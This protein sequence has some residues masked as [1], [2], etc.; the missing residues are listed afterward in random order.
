MSQKINAI[1]FSNDNAAQL[2]IF[3]ESV[4]KN[5][6]GVFD[7]NIII[8]GTE[9]YFDEAYGRVVDDKRFSHVNFERETDDF[10]EQVVEN[11]NS[12]HDYACFFLD[13]NIIYKVI[14]LEDITSQIEADDDVVCFSLRLGENTTKCY[15][16]GAENVLNDIE[17]C[18]D[19]MKWDWTL[20][21]L[22]FGYP[23]SY[24]EIKVCKRRRVGSIF[25]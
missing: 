20:H 11:L 6:P 18:G 1:V 16:L 12:K 19:F 23:F 2:N 8:K 4:N 3:L 9:E 10:R 14:K 7:L 13:D 25:I 21:Y 24:K 22:D 15:T 5:A 17:D